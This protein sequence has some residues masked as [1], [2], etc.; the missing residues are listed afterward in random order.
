MHCD[1]FKLREQRNALDNAIV[2]NRADT[3]NG[4]GLAHEVLS[5]ADHQAILGQASSPSPEPEDYVGPEPW[6]R[7][8]GRLFHKYGIQQR[9]IS[10]LRSLVISGLHER[11]LRLAEIDGSTRHHAHIFDL[12]DIAGKLFIT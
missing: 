7:N 2:M 4:L 12:L 6:M 10:I 8:Q 5:G 11:I 9:L 1:S 3:A